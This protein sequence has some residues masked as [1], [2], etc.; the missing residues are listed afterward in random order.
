MSNLFCRSHESQ[1]IN[2]QMTIINAKYH[3]IN[4]TILL[5][6]KRTAKT[7]KTQNKWSNDR[8]SIVYISNTT[9]AM[10]FHYCI[11][12][13]SIKLLVIYNV[14]GHEWIEWINGMLF[15]DY[16]LYYYFCW[17]HAVSWAG[18][19]PLAIFCGFSLRFFF[20]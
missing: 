8:I 19:L 17:R 15:V 10:R 7:Y 18:T 5:Q 16:L 13:G 20:Y 11:K 9:P 1:S 3:L 14:I 12:S 2:N 6:T 4:W